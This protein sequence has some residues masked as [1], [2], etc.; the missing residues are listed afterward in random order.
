[1]DVS[2][3]V[4]PFVGVVIAA[5]LLVGAWNYFAGMSR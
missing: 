4:A 3:F 1:V 5:A 2:F